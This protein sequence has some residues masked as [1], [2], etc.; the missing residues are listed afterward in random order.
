MQFS[1]ACPLLLLSGLEGSEAGDGALAVV[2]ST[3][4]SGHSCVVAPC[5]QVKVRPESEGLLLKCSSVC[6]RSPLG[7]ARRPQ[8]GELSAGRSHLGGGE[9]GLLESG[10][11]SDSRSW[12]GTSFP[13]WAF[14]TPYWH[15]FSEEG[16]GRTQE[17]EVMFL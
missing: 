5:P 7:A 8:G 15:P 1:P 11:Q 14:F 17:E 3:W 13:V 10:E 9:A 12:N 6:G 2:G 16:R 4:G